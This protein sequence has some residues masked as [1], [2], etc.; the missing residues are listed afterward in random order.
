VVG[1]RLWPLF[2]VLG[3]DPMFSLKRPVRSVVA[4]G[5]AAAV[6][7]AGLV[8]TAPGAGAVS[9]HRA[10]VVGRPF[11]LANVASFAGYD[12]AADSKG[13]AYIG[14]ISTTASNSAR[15]VHFCRLPVGATSCTGGVQTIDSLDAASAAGLQVVVTGAHLVHLIWFHDTSN[16]INGPQRSAIAEATAQDGKNLTPAHDVVTNAP[17]FGELLTAVRGPNGS[18]WTV[19]YPGLSTHKVQV[20]AGL[21]APAVSVR[22]P[23]GVGYAQLAFAG[24]K[25][26][27]AV[28][29]YGSIGASPH[30][31]SRSSAG[32][33]SSFRAV[34]H[35]WAVGTNAAVATSRHGL[36]LVTG[37]N[38][39]SY[40][41]TISKWTSNG[42]APRRL[43]ADHNPC[44][45]SS[46][47]GTADASGRF[48]DVSW[49]CHDVTITN[50]ADALHAGIVRF[51]V[52]GTPTNQAQI[53]SG[54]R[55]I[56]TVVYST[57]KQTGQVLRAAHVRLPGRTHTVKHKGAG[58]RVTVTGPL[59]C[60]PPVTVHIGW[61][62]RAARK[63]TFDTGTLRLNGHIV[64]SS[65]LDGAKLAAGKK[66]RLIGKAVFGKGHHRST[67]TTRLNFRTCANG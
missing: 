31:A 23:Y 35:T 24:G 17:S 53:A 6:A 66:Y 55:G 10:G 45:P 46:H 54:T 12:V 50:Y 32:K 42:F 11:T 8:A 5:A 15:M 18:I 40:R 2:H 57:E 21:S 9:G 13:T 22:A 44:A 19:T 27:L 63:W 4:F 26:V 56:A 33:W 28:E 59:S 34:A 39:A 41:P 62:H 16:S 37:V 43:T 64:S 61:T 30:Y 1:F 47:D 51:S 38:N 52:N 60:L 25:P 65:K 67:V 20:R 29:K 49:E 14:W 3:E 58:G 36:R 48:L 7:V